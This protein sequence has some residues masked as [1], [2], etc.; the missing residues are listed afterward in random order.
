MKR[1]EFL[2]KGGMLAAAG[3]V[4][5]AALSRSTDAVAATVKVTPNI[6]DFGAK[7]D[8]ITDDAAAFRKALTVSAAQGVKVVVPGF[9]YA[10]NTPINWVSS[11][12]AVAVWGLQCEGATLR[13]NIKNGTDVFSMESKH[14]LRYFQIGGGL[15]IKCSGSD[16]HGFRLYAGASGGIYFYNAAIDRLAVE[17][18]GGDCMLIEGNVFESQFTN[19]YFQDAKGNGA[20]FAHSHGGIVSA[21]DVLG[22]YFNKNGKYGLN[23]TNFDSTSGGAADVRV[24]GGYCR[25]NKSYGFYYNNGT[26]PGAA[27]SQVGFENNC[28]SLKPGDPNGAHMYGM[29]R[30]QVRDC[31]GYNEFG[32]ATYMLRGYFT[33][34]TT[35][36]GCNQS[37][38][39]AMASTGK[40]RLVQVNG[41]ATGHVAMRSCGGGLDVTSSNKA[42]WQAV[43]CSGPSPL[44]TLKANSTMGTA[45]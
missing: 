15:S 18:A 21:I 11:G 33:A 40:S 37:A 3:V 42:T 39:G 8:G 1:R 27:I 25:E 23:C 12:N 28:T 10:I 38:G 34:V 6:F 14:L 35:L 44:G 41:A 45:V 7:G 20:T 32:G 17:G 19:C 24:V 29:V 30:M 43:N 22:C 13:S 16:R 2:T 5:G 31:A 36:D 4:G 26:A 9:T